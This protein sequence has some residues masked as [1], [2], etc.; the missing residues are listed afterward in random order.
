M[1]DNEIGER[2][3][4]ILRKRLNQVDWNQSYPG[5]FVFSTDDLEE[6]NKLIQNLKE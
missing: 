5:M 2:I 1:I 4:E 3:V 6:L